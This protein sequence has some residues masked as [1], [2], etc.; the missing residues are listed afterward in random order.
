LRQGERHDVPQLRRATAG[1]KAESQKLFRAFRVWGKPEAI[2]E[3][4]FKLAVWAHL[5]ATLKNWKTILLQFH[6]ISRL[7]ALDENAGP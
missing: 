6:D 2:D 3:M 1:I 5:S 4:H 7:I